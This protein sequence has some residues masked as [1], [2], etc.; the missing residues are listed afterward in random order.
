MKR[1]K[2]NNTL[3]MKPL[4]KTS[5]PLKKHIRMNLIL[6]MKKKEKLVKKVKTKV[7]QKITNLI[8]NFSTIKK[9]MIIHFFQIF[10]FLFL[11]FLLNIFWIILTILFQL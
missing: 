1:L 3:K 2:K 8:I 7:I 11:I 9:S 4:N 6:K 10:Y 5:L